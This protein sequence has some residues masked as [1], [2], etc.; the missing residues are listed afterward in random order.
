MSN[1]ARQTLK[2]LET[3]YHYWTLA[4]IEARANA[5]EMQVV[6]DR[7]TSPQKVKRLL[8]CP[9]T[10]NGNATDF[11]FAR[12]VDHPDIAKEIKDF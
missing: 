9:M 2:E 6:T 10:E 4:N 11:P 8:D 12:S 5:N 1:K 3:G 7:V